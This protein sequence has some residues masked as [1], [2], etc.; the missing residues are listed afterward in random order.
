MSARRYAL[1]AVLLWSTVAT[2]FKL[3]LRYVDPIDLV[4]AASAVSTLIFFLARPPNGGAPASEV[5]RSAALGLLNPCLYYLLLFEAYRRLPAQEALCLN[6]TWPLA[7]AV[8]SSAMSRR[9]LR[10]E[11]LIGLLMSLAGVV[12]VATRGQLATLHFEDPVGVAAA[13]ASAVVWAIYWRAN[14]A[15]PLDPVQRLRWNFVF[16]TGWIAAAAALTGSLD[17]AWPL[18]AVAGAVYV[19]AF[20]MG[21]TF[22]LWLKALRTAED[23]A[24]ISNLAYLA[25]V[26]SMVWIAAV[27]GEPPQIWTLAGLALILG[28]I[29]CTEGSARRSSNQ[30]PS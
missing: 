24:R 9:S 1:T 13:L 6:Y 2:A 7:L 5:R 23:A 3:S 12:V 10:K 26:L 17:G 15:D 11:I 25:P 20:E 27:L 14:A 21:I 8:L 28:G 19:G 18:P 30:D 22:L 4:L 16:G 29:A